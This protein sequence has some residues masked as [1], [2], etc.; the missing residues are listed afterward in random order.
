MGCSHFARR[1]SGNRFFFLFLRLL[2]CF[3]SPG[4]PPHAYVFSVGTIRAPRDQRSFVNSPGLFADFHALHRLLI[5]RHPP[6]A[7]NSLTTNIQSSQ[8]SAIV[9][10]EYA[11]NRIQCKGSY[12]PEIGLVSLDAIYAIQPNCQRSIGG[13]PQ[14][15]PVPN[16]ERGN[17]AAES[18]V[19]NRYQMEFSF[20][21]DEGQTIDIGI[22]APA[23]Y[24]H[25]SY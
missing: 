18:L 17:L 3:S 1:Y 9:V 2:R 5:P 16:W 11:L 23:L 12:E 21:G 25:G 14:V 15:A 19:V 20:S 10:N 7:L 6:C 22:A 13:N 24:P 4:W 8:I